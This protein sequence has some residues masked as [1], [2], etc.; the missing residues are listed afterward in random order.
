MEDYSADFL[1]ARFYKETAL[2]VSG[3]IDV[4]ASD[5]DA[6]VEL[7]N[8]SCCMA[9]ALSRVLNDEDH[10][11][12]ADEALM[13]YRRM[14][15]MAQF[16]KDVEDLNLYLQSIN[17]ADRFY[18][19]QRNIE[20]G[21]RVNVPAETADL[22]NKLVLKDCQMLSAIFNGL[23]NSDYLRH[24]TQ[25]KYQDLPYCGPNAFKEVIAVKQWLDKMQR[26]NFFG[27]QKPGIQSSEARHETLQ[28]L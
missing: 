9:Q 3:R 17:I 24:F 26:D 8:R 23:F 19:Y 12:F 16:E 1:T 11:M 2:P 27:Q 10:R 15:D 28:P 21:V 4:W 5:F 20:Q 18:P 14:P 6:Y 13:I 22:L 7:Y 25:M